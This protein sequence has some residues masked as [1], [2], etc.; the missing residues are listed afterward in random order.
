MSDYTLNHAMPY[1]KLLMTSHLT[2]K[3]KESPILTTIY[4]DLTAWPQP[5]SKSSPATSFLHTGIQQQGYL[6]VFGHPTISP[7]E[8]HT[9]FYILP[10]H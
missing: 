6:A 8:A 3:K 1:F 10:P 4:K 7:A 2:Q 9:H 5:L